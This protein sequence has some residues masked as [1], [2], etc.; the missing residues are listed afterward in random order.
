MNTSPFFIQV[1][2]EASQNAFAKMVAALIRQ[3]LESNP[4]KASDFN[5]LFGVVSLVAE[6]AEI[7]ITLLFNRGELWVTD[8]ITGIPDI[9]I[10]GS[11]NHILALSAI[12]VDR[13]WT[14]LLFK[15]ADRAGLEAIK[16]L[17][18]AV[19]QAELRLYGVWARPIFAL[20]L[21]RIMSV[22]S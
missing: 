20:R 13:L 21:T 16:N 22:S 11:S 17:L 12:P 19:R 3:N 7:A 8:G 9:T 2:P 1:T 4:S 15:S 5:A 18:K 10:R 14:L 6:D